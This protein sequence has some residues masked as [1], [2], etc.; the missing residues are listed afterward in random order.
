MA[1]VKEFHRQRS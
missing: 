1:E